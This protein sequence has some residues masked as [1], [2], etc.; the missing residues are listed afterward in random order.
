MLSAC[1]EGETL[2]GMLW[3]CGAGWHLGVQE[4][5]S[6]REEAV[7]EDGCTDPNAAEPSA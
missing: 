3:G 7:A 1:F 5:D 4:S 6:L 2:S